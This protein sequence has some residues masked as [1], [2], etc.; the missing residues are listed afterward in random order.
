MLA[1]GFIQPSSSSAGA[2]VIFAKKPKAD[3]SLRLCIDYRGLNRVTKKNR[4]PVPLIP[5]LID[6][7]RNAKIFTKIDLKGAYNLVRVS[8]GDEWKPRLEP[9]LDFSNI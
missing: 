8:E 4:Y 3:G 6:R 1:K 5:Q 2:P 7:L 9:A